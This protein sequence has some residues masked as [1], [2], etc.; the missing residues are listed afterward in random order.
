MFSQSKIIVWY[1]VASQKVILGE[2]IS[3]NGDVVS[4]WRHA[5]VE[6]NSISYQGYR[7]SLLDDDGREI[8]Y[9]SVSMGTADEILFGFGMNKARA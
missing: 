5:P 2:A 7:L 4:L 1:E 6:D 3:G 8:G 9:K